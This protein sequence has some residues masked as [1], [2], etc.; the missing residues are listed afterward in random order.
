M[1]TK[2]SLDGVDIPDASSYPSFNINKSKL[3]S[4]F[5]AKN[6]KSYKIDV[7]RNKKDEEIERYFVF[8]KQNRTSFRFVFL[9]L[10]I[11]DRVVF[12]LLILFLAFRFRN[13]AVF[14]S[15]K[16]VIVT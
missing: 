15:D 8:V 11:I 16:L 14:R 9:L 5:D 12:F 1:H 6:R 7:R 10:G 2:T 3:S 4:G 13:V